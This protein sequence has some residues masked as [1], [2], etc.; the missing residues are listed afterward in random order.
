MAASFTG[1]HLDL[2]ED[3]LLALRMRLSTTVVSSWA[4]GGSTESV[5]IIADSTLKTN[6]RNGSRYVEADEVLATQHMMNELVCVL[7]MPGATLSKLVDLASEMTERWLPSRLLVVW[8]GNEY[9]S[10]GVGGV[11]DLVKAQFPRLLSLMPGKVITV[12]VPTYGEVFRNYGQGYMDFAMEATRA[13]RDWSRSQLNFEVSTPF[14]LDACHTL[15]SHIA[16]THHDELVK[17]VGDL[18]SM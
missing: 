14:R 6:S 4:T 16:S 11:E 2:M 5:L 9:C 7:C 13:A 8:Q 3:A 12:A 15:R 10:V 17:V 1:A 18:A